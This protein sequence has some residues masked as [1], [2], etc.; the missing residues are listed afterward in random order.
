MRMK[1]KAIYV[2]GWWLCCFLSL[3]AQ[4]TYRTQPLCGTIKTVKVV[5]NS[6]AF[7]APIMELNS[8]EVITVKFDNLAIEEPRIRYRLLHCNADWT[9]S[10]L[11]ETEYLRGFNNNV[12]DDY[13]FSENTSVPYIHYQ[14][15]FPNKDM[16]PLLS[17]NYTV[18]VYEDDNRENVLLTA[19]FSIVEPC[20]QIAAS[21][22]GVTDIDMHDAHQQLSFQINHPQLSLRD[23]MSELHVT[24]LQNN[25]LD[26]RQENIKPTFIN[27]NR[28]VFEHNRNLIFDAGNEY[29]R[30]EIINNHYNGMGVYKTR[31]ENPFYNATLYTDE[32][33]TNKSWLY[34]EDQN[35]RFFVRNSD[36]YDSDVEADYF[37][38][39]F[40][41]DTSQ[42]FI[43]PIYLNGDF[44]YHLF[45]PDTKMNFDSATGTYHQAVMLKQGAYNFQ[46]LCKQRKN[47][48][49]TSCLEGDYYETRN[50]YRIMV[51]YRPFGGRYDQ[52]IGFATV[53]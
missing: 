10:S 15:S 24:V 6:N 17:G 20:L 31:Y 42:P 48:Y 45:S 49:T 8:N 37:Q 28:L 30:F 47:R 29:R 40:S 43:E 26:N 50:E 41:L 18:E 9:P 21:V 32:A 1:T 2:I 39:H 23:P 14:L 11:S 4:K 36:A 5:A 16:Q 46:Y 7:A 33:R 3:Q 12:V 19:C 52:F 13:R 34:D 38:V 27:P 53:K 44:T 51:Y 22:S 35:G 25:R